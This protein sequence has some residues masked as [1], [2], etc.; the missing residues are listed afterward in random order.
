[1]LA[2]HL[3]KG[4]HGV[5]ASTWESVLSFDFWHRLVREHKLARAAARRQVVQ[6]L[7]AAAGPATAAPTTPRPAKRK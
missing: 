3:G 7:L 1:V 5:A 6:L 4:D 2:A